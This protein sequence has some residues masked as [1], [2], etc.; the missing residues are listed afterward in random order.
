MEGGIKAS[1]FITMN[2]EML[3]VLGI[4][5][6]PMCHDDPF[7]RIIISQ[8]KTEDMAFI[9]TDEKILKYDLPLLKA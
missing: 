7:D 4:E 1:G 6:L 5:K 3:H 9:T 2:I 8:A